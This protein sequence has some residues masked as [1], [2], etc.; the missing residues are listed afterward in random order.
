MEPRIASRLADL[1]VSNVHEITAP[2]FR[3]GG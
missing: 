3:L 2:D 1:Q